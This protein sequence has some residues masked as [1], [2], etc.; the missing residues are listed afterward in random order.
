MFLIDGIFKSLLVDYK[1][2]IVWGTFTILKLQPPNFSRF[3]MET[4]IIMSAPDYFDYV[5]K[6]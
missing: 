2:D 1:H 6:Y 4:S 3:K 5:S